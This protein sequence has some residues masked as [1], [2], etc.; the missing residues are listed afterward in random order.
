MSQDNQNNNSDSG[1]GKAHN[2]ADQSAASGESSMTQ[3]ELDFIR[4]IREQ[5]ALEDDESAVLV[6]AYLKNIP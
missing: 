1:N 6:A 3:E 5:L 4:K 2:N